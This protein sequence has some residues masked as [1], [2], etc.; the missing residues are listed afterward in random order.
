MEL[1]Q[2][3]CELDKNTRL[4]KHAVEY[5]IE[6]KPVYFCRDGRKDCCPYLKVEEKELYYCTFVTKEQLDKEIIRKW[7]TNIR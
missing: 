7:D 2:I 6:D 4:P 5:Y 1:E 3:A